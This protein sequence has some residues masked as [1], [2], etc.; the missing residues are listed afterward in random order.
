MRIEVLATTMNSKDDSLPRR[1][2]LQTDAII[3]NQCSYTSVVKQK[4]MD[5]AITYLNFDEK[6]VGLN[7]NNLLMRSSADVCILADDDMTFYDG[8][9]NVVQSAFYEK[10]NAEM[11]IFNIDEKDVTNR[12]KNKKYK[13]VTLLNY[14]N[15]GAVRIAFKRKTV[16][17]NACYFNLNF[18]GG[19]QHSS[20]E[21]SLFIRDCLR[22]GIK[23]YTAPYTLAYLNDDREST[24]FNGY[25]EKYFFDKGCFLAV[26]HPI[27]GIV[28]G[29]LLC[30]KHPFFMKKSGLSFFKIY[31]LIMDGIKYIK[32]NK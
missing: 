18:G 2:N 21:D 23:I 7:R 1:M 29:F 17:Y 22:K 25:N 9:S 15:Y 14:M 30:L 4:Y 24:W 20:G 28:F 8:Y 11:L 16:S 26:A 27:L 6:G 19:T 31:G 12:R 3:G 10:K 5:Y 13:R 32:S